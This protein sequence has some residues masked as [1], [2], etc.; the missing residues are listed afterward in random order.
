MLDRLCKYLREELETEVLLLTNPFTKA[1]RYTLNRE[2]A[3][4]VLLEYPDVPPDTSHLERAIRSLAVGHGNWVFFWTEIGVEYVGITQSLLS[5]CRVQGIDPYTY[6]VD[7]LQRM[8][9]HPTR[10]AELMTPRIWKQEFGESPLR[11]DLDR[12]K[13]ETAHSV[14]P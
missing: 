12:V 3:L 13:M 8:D 2:Q 5:T 9:T 14:T 1:A 6:L 11:S 4:R 7:V 10:E